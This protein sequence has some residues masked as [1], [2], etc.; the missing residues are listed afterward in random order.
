MHTCIHTYIHAFIHTIIHTYKHACIHIFIHTCIHTFIHT[1]IFPRMCIYHTSQQSTEERTVC[2]ISNPHLD[3]RLL[4]CSRSDSAFISTSNYRWASASDSRLKEINITNDHN[5]PKE[6][7]LHEWDLDIFIIKDSSNH[8]PKEEILFSPS[9]TSFPSLY[10]SEGMYEMAQLAFGPIWGN[11]VCK[12]NKLRLD[13]SESRPVF[14]LSLLETAH[15]CLRPSQPWW[16]F[17]FD[18]K[19][20]ELSMLH[21]W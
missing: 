15:L 6:N 12:V 11:P 20:I 1:C 10:F 8:P 19:A 4:C 21:K 16:N 5:K 3:A 7:G 14:Q 13:V 18:R 9:H 17:Y 2:N